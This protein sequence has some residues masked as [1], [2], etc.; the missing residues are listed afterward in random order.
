[1]DKIFYTQGIQN[2]CCVQ[3]TDAM[4]ESQSFYVYIEHFHKG[5]FCITWIVCCTGCYKVKEQ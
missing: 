3:Y 2:I 4:G 5:V 1:M